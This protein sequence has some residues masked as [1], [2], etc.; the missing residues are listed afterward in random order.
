MAEKRILG[1]SPL[2]KAYYDRKLR[3]AKQQLL[4]ENSSYFASLLPQQ[5][6][7]RLYPYFREQACFLDIET[8]G[9]RQRDRIILF[10]WSD[11]ERY[12]A[13]IRG[14]NWDTMQLK[15]M[16]QQYKLLV[17]FNGSS[18]D[19][20][21]ITKRF[22]GLLPKIPHMD[23]RHAA[24]RAGFTGSLKEIEQQLGIRRSEI[25]GKIAGGDVSLLWRRFQATGD[26]DYLRLLLE[27]NE[28]DV[29][30]LRRIADVVSARLA[31][32]A[33]SMHS[34]ISG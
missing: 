19:V 10:G 12:H 1:I 32:P 22:A 4:A 17:T 18:F 5:E 20:P 31:N 9:F 29:S 27:Y 13:M 3:G 14:M 16:L 15:K 8:T 2:R 26:E 6:H 23:L 7:W 24:A 30:N 21:F 34:N 25:I 33:A 28:E 11:G